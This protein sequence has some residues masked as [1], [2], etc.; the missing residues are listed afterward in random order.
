MG[1]K[2]VEGGNNLPRALWFVRCIAGGSGSLLSLIPPQDL[3][4]IP[5]NPES[6][7]ALACMPPVRGELTATQ[8]TPFAIWVALIVGCHLW[9]TDHVTLRGVM[10]R[11]FILI[12]V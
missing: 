3:A 10:I 2:Q 6:P 4:I 1:R 7:L 11:T 8:D 12:F 5:I 9:Y